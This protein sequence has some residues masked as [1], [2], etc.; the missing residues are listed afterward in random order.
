MSDF[1]YGY[2]KGRLHGQEKIDQLCAALREIIA[3][4]KTEHS[5]GTIAV[6][7]QAVLD[8]MESERWV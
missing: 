1:Y 8:E 4:T 2:D 5:R 6:Y 7:A 3:R